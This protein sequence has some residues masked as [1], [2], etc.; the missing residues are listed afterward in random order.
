MLTSVVLVLVYAAAGALSHALGKK[1]LD[2]GLPTPAFLVLRSLTGVLTAALIFAVLWAR[3]GLPDIP[4]GAWGLA[5]LTG[6]CHPV[7]SNALYFTGLRRGDLSVMSP[8]INTTPLFTAVFAGV[9][10]GE[11]QS[12]L[13]LA[14]IGLILVGAVVVPL[15]SAGRHRAASGR[16]RAV[17]SALLGI[18]SAVAVALYLV[19]GRQAMKSVEPRF[20]ALVLNVMALVA[21]STAGAAGYT[22]ASVE[23]RRHWIP[24]AHAAW[25]TVASGVLVYGLC[26]FLGLTVLKQITASLVS[27]LASTAAVFAL[28]FSIV[29]LGERPSRERWF[30]ALLVVTGCVLC[31]LG[32]HQ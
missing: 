14:G 31:S 7:L 1:A 16:G 3:N 24:S 20:V 23:D 18:G 30:G 5:A 19:C 8:L 11:T 10:L 9:F 27:A 28:I 21:F 32:R 25:L 15:S 29:L 6:L 13:S 4:P 12:P 2:T 17:D 26:C 22:R